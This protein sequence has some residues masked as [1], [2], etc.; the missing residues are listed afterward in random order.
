[1]QTSTEAFYSGLIEEGIQKRLEKI[2]GTD[3]LIHERRC[4]P[5]ELVQLARAELEIA[6]RRLASRLDRSD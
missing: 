3:D 6:F 5:S 2:D 4:S 1:M